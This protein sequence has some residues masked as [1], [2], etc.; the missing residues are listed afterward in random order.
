MWRNFNNMLLNNSYLGDK[1]KEDIKKFI[2]E[3]II[4]KQFTKVYRTQKKQ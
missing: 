1:I 3:M 4:K 2:E